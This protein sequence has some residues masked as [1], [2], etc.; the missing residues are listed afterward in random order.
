MAQQYSDG[1]AVF[2]VEEW[3]DFNSKFARI[4]CQTSHL[5]AEVLAEEWEADEGGEA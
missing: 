3:I 1:N 4:F 2:T 5:W